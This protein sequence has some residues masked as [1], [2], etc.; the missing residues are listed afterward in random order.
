M[1][2]TRRKKIMEE[3]GRIFSSG[4]ITY[5]VMSFLDMTT[6]NKA[7]FN[8]FILLIKLFEFAKNAG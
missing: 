6:K 8:F 1:K 2:K 3:I 7:E 4:I 5:V